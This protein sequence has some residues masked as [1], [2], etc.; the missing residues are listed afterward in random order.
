MMDHIICWDTTLYLPE[1]VA[2]SK[3]LVTV[4]YLVFELPIKTGY[5]RK[6]TVE[7]KTQFASK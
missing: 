5:D 4:S 7:W 6:P 2:D 1:L 3:L